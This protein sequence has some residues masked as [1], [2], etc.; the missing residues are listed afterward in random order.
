MK[1]TYPQLLPPFSSPND[2]LQA[3][4]GTLYFYDHFVIMKMKEGITI[5]YKNGISLLLKVLS[6]VGAKPFFLISDREHSYAIEPVDYEH[7]NKVPNLK[8]IAIV[9]HRDASYKSAVL[10]S[11]FF[12]KP[13]KTF[14]N[15]DDAVSWTQSILENN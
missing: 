5:N 9:C 2:V 4:L 10:E 1:E 14:E 11:N 13:F 6:K 15:L 8:G 12:K 7:L 3:S